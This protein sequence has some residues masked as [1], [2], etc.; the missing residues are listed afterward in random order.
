MFAPITPKGL[1]STSA[2]H[3]LRRAP[4]G[5]APGSRPTLKLTRYRSP[6]FWHV[7][8]RKTCRQLLV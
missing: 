8:A 4:L 2:E 6:T 5:I 3:V 7:L 1:G